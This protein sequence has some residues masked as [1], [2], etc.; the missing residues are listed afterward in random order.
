LRRRVVSPRA[1]RFARARRETIDRASFYLGAR[2]GE[3]FFA[4]D[5]VRRAEAVSED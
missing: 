5:G 1:A 4:R 2:H 3:S